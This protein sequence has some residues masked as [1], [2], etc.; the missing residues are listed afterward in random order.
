MGLNPLRFWTFSYQN[1]FMK[2]G[3]KKYKELC[4]SPVWALKVGTFSCAPFSQRDSWR[5]QL[6]DILPQILQTVNWIISRGY[7][8]AEH[9]SLSLICMRYFHLDR[10]FSVVEV[11]NLWQAKK[12]FWSHVAMV[13]R[14]NYAQKIT[15]L[16]V[17]WFHLHG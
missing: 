9:V 11:N 15:I 8:Q 7:I 5:F 17:K 12:M 1:H 2:P 16:H 13:K 4:N 3:Q 14:T 6:T 10:E